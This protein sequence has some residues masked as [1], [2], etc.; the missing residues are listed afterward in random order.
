M[1]L[2]FVVVFLLARAMA[3]GEELFTLA[4]PSHGQQHISPSTTLRIHARVPIDTGRWHTSH[5]G[6][7]V[8]RDSLAQHTPREQW[9]QHKVVGRYTLV[10]QYTFTWQPRR[11]LPN[12]RYRCVLGTDEYVFT[13]AP[14]V[15]C[16]VSFDLQDKVIL[17]DN[18]LTLRMSGPLPGG[19]DI[20]SVLILE[21]QHPEGYWTD[22][23]HQ[24]QVNGEVVTILPVDTWRTH[25]MLR[26][27][28]RS[29]WYAGDVATDRSYEAMVRGTTRM[30]CSM[31]IEPQGTASP[32]AAAVIAKNNRVVIAGD[33]TYLYA[34]HVVDNRFQFSHWDSESIQTIRNNADEHFFVLRCADMTRDLS[35]TAVYKT[36]DSLSVQ[37]N[38]HTAGS[39]EV[40]DVD[41]TLLEV[42]NDTARIDIGLNEAGVI[43]IARPSMGAAFLG[44]DVGGSLMPSGSIVLPTRSA[45][46]TPNISVNPRFQV[47]EPTIDEEY[48]LRAGITDI[49]ANP[50]FNVSDAV[51]F[52]TANEFRSTYPKTETVCILA[53]RCWEIIGYYDQG[54]GAP[55][56][57]EQG[58]HDY[59]LT[60]E[61]LNPENL[62]VFYVRRK[63]IDLRIEDVLLASEDPTDIM[64][65]RQPHPETKVEVQR[66]EHI[67]GVRVWITLV[68]SECVDRGVSTARYHVMCGDAIRFI[69]HPAQHRGQHWRWW[70]NVPGYATPGGTGKQ[71][72]TTYSMI[73]DEDLARFEARDCANE[74]LA[75]KEIRLQA[76]FRQEMV[77]ESIGL[78]VRVNARG[79]RDNARFEERW[80]D[81]L[82][83]YD[84]DNDEPR[85]GRQLEYVPRRG[86]PV[87]LRFSLPLDPESVFQNAITAESFDNILL[88]NPH[89]KDV[90]FDVT[91][92]T[93]GNTNLLSSTG[94][95]LDI[96][97]FSICK[98]YT[99]PRKQ[100]L[101]TGS[102]DLTLRTRIKAYT[103]EPLRASQT[104]A[105]RRMEIP[106]FGIK[107]CEQNVYDDGDWDLWPFVNRGELYHAVYGGNLTATNA[108]QTKHGFARLPNCDDQQGAVGEC[109]TLHGDEDGPL[110]FG[111]RAIWLQSSWMDQSDL[112]WVRM[113]TWDE[114]CKDD[115]DCLVNNLED[116]VD[117]LRVRVA[118]YNVP[119]EFAALDWKMLIPD[120]IKTGVDLIDAFVAPDDQDDFISECTILQDSQELWG[121]KTAQAPF[122]TR[123]HENADY[124]FKGQW[125]TTRAVVR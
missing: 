76:A 72:P 67:G 8:L 118:K 49:D 115:N 9:T 61:L 95:F 79:E 27:K 75:H 108:L 26:L 35:V 81:P 48:R 43:C 124:L 97:E 3:M 50:L 21:Q 32:D 87:R 11:L 36:L 12:T 106:G 99:T 94:Q 73:I 125:Y 111:E 19:I 14:D 91:A 15:P 98:P 120:I 55:V 37:I 30:S 90:D 101:H 29:S 116:V 40:F 25:S 122:I 31:R 66:Q 103:G 121:M 85:D 57:F 93:S 53:E 117:S 51:R 2:R 68:S 22:A 123:Y 109:T 112:A 56:W 89:D 18:A 78:R 113:A 52:T 10:D 70:S 28:V 1:I 24:L 83:Y 5:A 20:D 47:L 60:A 33:T 114:D 65:Q 39:V 69:I 105:L 58:L 63:A 17:C 71:H 46:V 92:D 41:G 59:C 86:T 62:V 38:I 84:R 96:V 13:T 104:L 107:I 34:P 119:I 82:T 54:I 16:P 23:P 100:A 102:I 77:L 80:F 74:P 45:K 64:L 7:L 6:L 44:W 42:L 4:F 88:A 110:K